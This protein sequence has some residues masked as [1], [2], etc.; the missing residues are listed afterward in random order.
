MRRFIPVNEPL[1][2]KHDISSVRKILE[3]GWISAEGPNVRNF[4]NKFSKFIGHKY[5]VTVTNGT[6]AL[7]IAVQSLNLPKN[8]EV[9]IPNFTIFSNAIACLKNNLKIIPIDCSKFDWNMNLQL[10]L[11]N[12]SSKTKLIIATH[13]YNY[14]IEIDKL[15]KICKKNKILLLEDAA[16]VFGQKYKNKM[17]G[18]FGDLST[19]SFY[20]NKQITTGEGG[21][22]T[23]NSKK[24]YEK[25]KNLR[26]LSFGKKNRFNHEDISS[27]NRMSNIQAT[28]GLS[29]LIRINDIVKKRHLIGTKYFKYLK[30]NSNIYIP[31]PERKFVKNI[32]WVVGVLITN[33][34][35]NIDAQ[36]VM[37]KLKEKR[38]GTRPFFWP[39]HK[40]KMLKNYNF[41]NSKKYANSEYICKYGFYLPSSLSLKNDEIEYISKCVNE[42]IKS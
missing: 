9:I 4:E 25:I 26:N 7:E 10:I 41:Y 21:M 5:G 35:L 40:Q 17:C 42:I 39:M 16:E 1:I 11:K 23:T 24:L 27:N 12:I 15:K 6:A 13:I 18:S 19:Y 34:N 33:T 20:A 38:I 32:Y 31:E 36:Y 29:Q 14:P 30:K 22:I 37:K 3:E 2:V 8:S 28:L